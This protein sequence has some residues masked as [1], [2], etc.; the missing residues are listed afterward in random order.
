MK[1]IIEKI[2]ENKVRELGNNFDPSKIW[3]KEMISIEEMEDDYFPTFKCTYYGESQTE[4]MFSFAVRFSYEN[5]YLR[6]PD[7]NSDTE[8]WIIL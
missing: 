8:I 6:E 3:E 1:K 4:G 5:Q 2:I 7:F